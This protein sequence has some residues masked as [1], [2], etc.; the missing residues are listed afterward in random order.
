MER[1]APP[2][3][4]V[5]HRDVILFGGS[6]GSIEVLK[7]VVA[8]LPRDLPAALLVVVHVPSEATSNLAHIFARAGRLRA[9]QAEH[10]E[11]IEHGTVYVARPDHHLLVNDGRVNLTR[12]PRV[13][14]HRPAVDA[15]FWSAARDLG[16]RSIAVVLS[17]ALDDGAAG[18]ASI[19]RHGGITV[20]QSPEHARHAS[21]PASAVA[22]GAVDHIVEVADLPGLLENL[23]KVG[24][25][26]PRGAPIM[27][28]SDDGRPAADDI[29]GPPSTF[30]CPE[31]HGVLWSARRARSRAIDV[32]SVTATRRTRSRT[33]RAS[34]W[35]R[36][37]GRRTERSSI[38][39]VST[40]TSRTARA[41]AARR[42]SRD[43]TMR[44]APTSSREQSSSTPP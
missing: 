30:V 2:M 39:R 11:A 19:K 18:I 7:H 24:T 3:E 21:M 44:V 34:A 25:S 40:A 43:T 12:G 4:R 41:R 23:V 27:H 37:S 22:T 33:R 1:R 26:V 5:P 31:C 38:R 20:A 29:K 36:R 14:R 42:T 9:K 16:S 10:G 28:A 35:R 17:G 13:N 32:T 15:L 8:E 6:A